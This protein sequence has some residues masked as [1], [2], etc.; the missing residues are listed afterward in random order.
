M[1]AMALSYMLNVCCVFLC[2][3]VCDE[4]LRIISEKMMSIRDYVRYL[5]TW[6]S[7]NKYYKENPNKEPDI[8]VEMEEDLVKIFKAKDAE[9][10]VRVQWPI[11]V[12]LARDNQ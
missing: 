8:L 4:R 7:I 3:C 1:V 12:V 5:S 9:H 10:E 6:S 2:V 11:F